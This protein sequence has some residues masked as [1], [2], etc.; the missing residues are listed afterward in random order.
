MK[1]I[2]FFLTVCALALISCTGQ[3]S[4]VSWEGTWNWEKDSDDLIFSI[5]IEAKADGFVGSYCA[6]AQG[7]NRID[8]G[9]KGDEPSFTI[10]STKHKAITVEFKSYYGGE[11]GKAKIEIKSGKLMWQIMEKPTAG[12]Y[13]CPDDAILIKQ[14]Q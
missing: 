8:C 9:I 11:T 5:T 10:P 4:T 3:N 14:S 2:I 13:F 7:G 1:T 6:V 12:M